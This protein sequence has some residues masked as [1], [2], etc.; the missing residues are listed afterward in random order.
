[1]SVWCTNTPKHQARFVEMRDACFAPASAPC[2]GLAMESGCEIGSMYKAE[3][4]REKRLDEEADCELDVA[5]GL[6]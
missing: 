1:M 5:V 2:A 4:S 6:S 3:E